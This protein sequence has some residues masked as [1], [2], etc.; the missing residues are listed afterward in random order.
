MIDLNSIPENPGCYL[1][2]DDSGKIIYIGKARNLKKRVSSYFQKKHNDPK[3]E[4]LINKT[5]SVDFIVTDNEVEALIL[6]NSMIK[7]NQPKYNI[8]LKD[9]KNYAYINL[10]D[11]DYPRLLIARKKTGKGKFYGPFTSAN[12]RDYVIEFLNKTFK[13]RTCSKMHKKPCLRHH[14][15]LCT[16][17]CSGSVSREEYNKSIDKVRMILGGKINEAAD[18]LKK[19]MFFYSGSLNFEKAM[20]IKHQLNALSGLSAR[21]NVDR[22]KKYDEDIINYVVKD[23]KVYLV[24]FNIFKGMLSDKSEFVFDYSPDFLEEFI[25]QY[26]SEHAVPEELILPHEIDDSLISFLSYAKKDFGDKSGGFPEVKKDKKVKISVPEKGDKK[27]L[28][29]LAMKNIEISFFGDLVKLEELKSKLCLKN[30]P[31]VIECFDISHLSGT[32]TV[33]SMVQF[34]NSKPDKNNY[35]RFKI[36]TVEGIDDVSAIA[37]VVR[38]R[39]L[40][41]KNE[42]LNFPDLIII[43]GGIGQLNSALN[44]LK[45]LNLKIPVISIA[46]KMEEIYVPNLRHPIKLNKKEKALH[47]IQ[48]IRDEAHRF[49]IKY[50]RLLTKKKMLE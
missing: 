49:A 31:S 30:L 18:S 35:R 27:Q 10:T 28:L 14:I 41:L 20:E 43:D 4:A 24:L 7:K 46:K 19:E 22:E 12:E 16:A 26:Y 1:F 17:P 38:R 8:D 34:R 40:R 2:K 6:E 29:D 23:G 9:S 36:K 47:L 3:T 32:S 48:E 5:D 45:K 11:E 13:L 37:E 21:Q 25:V 42:N 39:Y 50:N 15:N 33:G 44:E